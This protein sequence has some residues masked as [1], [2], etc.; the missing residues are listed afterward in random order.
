MKNNDMHEQLHRRVDLLE[1][2]N[3]DDIKTISE[4][5]YKRIKMTTKEEGRGA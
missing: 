2:R 4:R 3:T 1:K 5:V